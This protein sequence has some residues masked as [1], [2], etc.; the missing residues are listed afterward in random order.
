VQTAAFRTEERARLLFLP[1]FGAALVLAATVTVTVARM[2]SRPINGM[3]RAMTALAGGDKSVVIPGTDRR[4]EIGRMA[5]AVQVFKT[6][7]MEADQLRAEQTKADKR[8]VREKKSVMDKLANEF[9]TAVGHVVQIASSASTELEAAAG[10][11]T[12]RRTSQESFPAASPRFPS[13]LPPTCNRSLP[14]PRK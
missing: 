3:T 4:D 2:M 14:R 9:E 8:A 5:E 6:K 10:T 12:K 1:L 7:I 11:L 13:K